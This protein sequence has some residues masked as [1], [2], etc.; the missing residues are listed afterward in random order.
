MGGGVAPETQ[1]IT[2][3][4]PLVSFAIGDPLAT[5][6]SGGYVHAPR[7]STRDTRTALVARLTMAPRAKTR[8]SIPGIL[9]GPRQQRRTHQTSLNHAT[10]RRA[11]SIDLG[12]TIRGVGPGGSNPSR[13]DHS[14]R[15]KP[16]R[17][18][19]LC[20]ARSCMTARHDAVV[21]R[22][23]TRMPATDRPRGQFGADIRI[24]ASTSVA[25]TPA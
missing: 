10:P 23:E 6:L 12:G 15:L 14:H 13:P 25:A 19:E 5:T 20:S 18:R 16:P 2:R 3:A 11:S 21:R 1:T 7:R 4:V 24:A 9:H 17:R 8:T 22:Q